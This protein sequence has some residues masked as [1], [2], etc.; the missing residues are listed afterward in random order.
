VT[1]LSRLAGH[2]ITVEEVAPRV[3]RRFEEVFGRRLEP[4][5]SI[6]ALTLAGV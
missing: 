2:E 5:P 3:A 1:S 6:E 4:H